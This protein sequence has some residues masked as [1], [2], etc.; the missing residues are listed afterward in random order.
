MRP[1]LPPHPSSQAFVWQAEVLPTLAVSPQLGEQRWKEIILR[2]TGRET[3]FYHR[4]T[5]N[6]VKELQSK[7]LWE[8][9]PYSTNVFQCTLLSNK[10]PL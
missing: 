7:R 5:A 9:M 10:L 3:A 4:M 6:F 1:R 8:V 2:T